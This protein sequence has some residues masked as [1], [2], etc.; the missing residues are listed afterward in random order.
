MSYGSAQEY[1][2]AYERSRVTMQ[3]HVRD[4]LIAVCKIMDASPHAVAQ[5]AGV[6][7]QTLTQI[8][9]HQTS[10]SIPSMITLNRISRI[11]G[12]PISKP[13]LNPQGPFMVKAHESGPKRKPA[14]QTV[15]DEDSLPLFQGLR[16]R[17]AKRA[18]A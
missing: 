3:T 4:W 17:R 12:V 14:D 8:L 7:P 15:K 5:M 10:P 11:S 13:I 1:S 18:F 16:G 6:S 2:L 9:Y